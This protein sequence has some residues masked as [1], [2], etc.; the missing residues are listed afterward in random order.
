MSTKNCSRYGKD[1]I[2]AYTIMGSL[3]LCVWKC[4]QQNCWV[5]LIFNKLFVLV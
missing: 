1:T 3:S 5:E 2:W 4:F